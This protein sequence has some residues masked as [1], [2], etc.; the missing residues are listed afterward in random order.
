MSLVVEVVVPEVGPQSLEKTVKSLRQSNTEEPFSDSRILFV[1][2]LG[3]ALRES[4]EG[5]P[6]ILALAFWMRKSEL[7][8]LREGYNSSIQSELSVPQGTVFHIPPANVDTLFV[9]TFVLSVLAGNR[10]I[11]RLS[12]RQTLQSNLLIKTLNRVL[13]KH[14]SISDA[15][16]MI[17]YG[18]D[19]EITATISAACDVRVVWGGDL[20]VSEIRKVP[21]PPHASELTFPDRFSMAAIDIQKYLSLKDEGKL[22]LVE[23]FYNDSYWFDLLGC[24]SSRLIIWIG[25]KNYSYATQDFSTK[26]LDVIR[27]KGYVADTAASIAKMVYALGS[28]VSHEVTSYLH[29]TNELTIVDVATFPD[30]R[31]SFCGA[32]LFHQLRLDSLANIIAHIR[33]TDQ[34]LAAFGFDREELLTFAK[35]LRGRGIDRIVPFGSAL[36]F[37]KI[38]DGYDLL[39]EFTRK[40]FI[41]VDSL[42]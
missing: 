29:P 3:K 41:Q 33:R 26:L 23:K 8:R 18:H 21:L 38:W 4:G 6:E 1:T 12:S 9:Y 11:V 35:E 25:Q 30:I 15:T 34:T 13:A 19:S 36:Q 10:N 17:L 5:F 42:S 2:E 7:I 39:S 22:L 14:P 40:V 37:N 20:A 24:S 32:G 16:S 31:G 27:A 28:A